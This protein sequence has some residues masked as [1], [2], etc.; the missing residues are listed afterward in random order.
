MKYCPN[1]ILK[2]YFSINF[3][4]IHIPNKKN[5]T[6]HFFNISPFNEIDHELSFSPN[7]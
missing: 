2:K 1:I 3:H 7:R 6:K 5:K 4:I